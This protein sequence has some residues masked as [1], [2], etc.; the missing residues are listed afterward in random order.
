MEAL[1]SLQIPGN[2]TTFQPL[3]YSLQFPALKTLRFLGNQLNEPDFLCSANIIPCS[4]LN[5]LKL[6]SGCS[7]ET[8]E[9]CS[10]IFPALTTLEIYQP[11]NLLLAKVWS[12]WPA[13]VHLR[14]VCVQGNHGNQVYDYETGELFPD[15]GYLEP[16]F[17]GKSEQACRQDWD[18]KVTSSDYSRGSPC[19]NDLK[20]ELCVIL[21]FQGFSISFFVLSTE[22]QHL[23]LY[24]L[25]T[26]CD[27]VEVRGRLV[28]DLLVYQ[29]LIYMKHLKS[30]TIS[31][32]RPGCN[33]KRSSKDSG[34]VSKLVTYLNIEIKL[35]SLI[36]LNICR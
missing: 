25:S 20:G 29:A 3:N 12:A 1:I 9:I 21:G 13:L 24:F 17:L 10:R 5:S 23:Q 26:E 28:T 19:I 4:T 30:L 34:D 7:A 32:W 35:I 6:P 27:N 16:G 8:I 2:A 31:E 18:L 22:L 14:M 11:E 15:P 33:G 36:P